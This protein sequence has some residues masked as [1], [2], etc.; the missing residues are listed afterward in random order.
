[1]S[2]GAREW[3]TLAAELKAEALRLGLARVGIAEVGPLQDHQGFLRSWLA[4]GYHGEMAWMAREEAVRRRADPTEGQGV[5]RSV[6]V[7]ADGYPHEDPPGVPDDPSRGVIA[8]YARGADYHRVLRSKLERLQRWLHDRLGSEGRPGRAYVDTGPVLEREWARRAGIGWFGRNTMLIDPGRGSY[9]LLGALFLEVPLP[10][11]SA[12]VDDRCGTCSACLDGCPSGAL[13]GRDARGAPVI[14]ARRCVSYLT[15]ELRGPIPRE[16][17][18]AVGN[19]VFGC[20]ICQEV[21][22]WNGRFPSRAPTEPRYAARGPG[23]RPSGVEALPDETRLHPGTAGPAL[24]DLLRMDEA[25]WKAYT[26]GSPLRRA[27][28]AG[29]KRNVA[30][31]IGNWVGGQSIP[32]PNAVAVLVDALEDGSALV[33]AHAAWAL[34]RA[35]DAAADGALR[36]ARRREG[37]PSVLEEIE[38]ALAARP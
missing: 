6:V 19:R 34:G 20:D 9:F 24:V 5:A 27:G 2:R 8:R 13:L 33:R 11:D 26:R 18:P 3:A 10:P 38:G 17:R 37:E 12:F 22:P 4:Q 28:F 36:E 7:V 25:A 1:M 31:A 29:F 15:I 14:D 23:E 21:C 16:L 35:R 30:V 32:D